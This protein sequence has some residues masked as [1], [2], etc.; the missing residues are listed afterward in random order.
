MFYSIQQLYKEELCSR[1]WVKGFKVKVDQD[2]SSLYFKRARSLAP[3]NSWPQEAGDMIIRL[4]GH[5]EPW[6][7]QALPLGA[8]FLPLH[9][10]WKAGQLAMFSR[11][12]DIL[13]FIFNLLILMLATNFF[14]K[15]KQWEWNLHSD[16]LETAFSFCSIFVSGLE[17][18]VQWGQRGI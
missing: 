7:A 8:A 4:G 10:C 9:P 17:L 5:V 13:I 1:F 15:K 3:T 18:V 11:E 2:K 14:P 6:A 12:S 16:V